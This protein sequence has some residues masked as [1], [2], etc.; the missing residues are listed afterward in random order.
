[1]SLP[2]S[3]QI[4]INNIYYEITHST[5]TNISMNNIRNGV[6]GGLNHSNDP[7]PPNPYLLSSSTPFK[8]S[9]FYGYN[10][11]H[12]YKVYIHCYNNSSYTVDVTGTLTVNSVVTNFGVYGIPTSDYGYWSDLYI[13]PYVYGTGDFVELEAFANGGHGSIYLTQIYDFETIDGIADGNPCGGAFH[14]TDDLT[15][16]EVNITIYCYDA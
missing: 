11:N 12:Q 2:T 6:Y 10:H 5:T 16:T 4:S 14:I 3:G 8:I 13:Y 9:D 1:M 15:Y 7:S